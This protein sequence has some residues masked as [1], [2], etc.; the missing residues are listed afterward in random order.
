MNFSAIRQR[1]TRI[2]R[3]QGG[4][5]MVEL[6]I[7]LVIAGIILVGALKGTDMINKAKIERTVSDIRGLQGMILEHEKRTGRLAGDC[8]GDGIIGVTLANL[9]VLYLGANAGTATPYTAT[10]DPTNGGAA[11]QNCANSTSIETDINVP[12][13]DLRKAN[14]VD[15]TRTNNVLARN[16]SNDYY[17]IGSLTMAPTAALGA[18]AAPNTVNVITVHGIPLWMAKGIDVA[19]DGVVLSATTGAGG[20]LG[21]V[22]LL[23]GP[24]GTVSASG[25]VWPADASDD[26]L[27]TISYQFDR[28]VQ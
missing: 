25:A 21:R 4:F 1:Y 6:A 8:N 5:T 14:I 9:T 2:A 3:G 22:R 26:S 16:Q 18:Q 19:I 12:W 23:V 24:T 10:A 11:P 27:V 20:Q 28:M 17:G 7:V 15:P 13:Y